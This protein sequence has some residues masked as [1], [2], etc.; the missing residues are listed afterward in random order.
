MDRRVRGGEQKEGRSDEALVI[1][2][3][4]LVQIILIPVL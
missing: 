2:G 3:H 1:G 4:V